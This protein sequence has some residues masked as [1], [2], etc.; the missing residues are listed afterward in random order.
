MNVETSFKN[1]YRIIKFNDRLGARTDLASLRIHIE[2]TLDAGIT[3]IAVEFTSDSF[4]DSRA[5]GNLA[6]CVEMVNAAQGKLVVIQ[7]N[8]EI[9]DFLRIVGFEDLIEVRRSAE[10]LGLDEESW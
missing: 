4:L 3:H 10:E 9:A 8:S 2:E 6:K 5:I 1:G 7:P